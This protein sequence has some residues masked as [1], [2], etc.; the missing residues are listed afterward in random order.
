MLPELRTQGK[1]GFFPTFLFGW[2][3]KWKTDEFL[4]ET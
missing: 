3:F 2:Y 1:M 4:Q